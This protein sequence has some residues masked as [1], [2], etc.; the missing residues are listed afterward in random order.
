MQTYHWQRHEEA[1]KLMHICEPYFC[2][3]WNL[4]Q[5]VSQG[6]LKNM[7]VRSGEKLAQMLF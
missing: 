1:T 7:V 5:D 2:I 4:G 6:M 3:E